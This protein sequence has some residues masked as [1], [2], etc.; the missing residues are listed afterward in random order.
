MTG[1]FRT[2]S[3]CASL[4]LVLTA[5]GCAGAST[6]S[7]TSVAARTSA[8]VVQSSPARAPASAPV[9][10]LSILSPRAGAH[11]ASTLTVRVALSGARSGATPRF[12]YVLDRRLTRFGSARLTFHDLVPGRHRLEVISTAASP[13]RATTTFTVRAPAPVAVPTQAQPT[14]STPVPTPTTTTPPATETT[15]PAPPQSSGGIP[16]GANAGD[17]DSDNHGGPSDGDG[18]I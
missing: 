12:R 15:T 2:G 8:S 9:A 6:S 13:I 1:E 14:V 3:L 11:T 17:G 16:Q 7:K 18:N 5:S 4:A 10:H